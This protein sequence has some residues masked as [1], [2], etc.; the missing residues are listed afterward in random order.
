MQLK[1]N[2]LITIAILLVGCV[3]FFAK[4]GWNDAILKGG[5]QWG[6]NAYLTSIFI[7]GDLPQL[8]RSYEN[9]NHQFGIQGNPK[10]TA[11]RILEAPD[12]PNGNR[13]LKYTYGVAALQV[14]FFLIA[15]LIFNGNG[16]TTPYNFAIYLSC[17]FYVVFGLVL[18]LNL[19]RGF[20]S[21]KIAIASILILFFGSNLFYF[22]LCYPGLSHPYLFFLFACLAHY[23]FRFYQSP[24]YL[25]A[26]I[27]G[28][29]T[30]L[31]IITRPVEA[32]VFIIPL[33]Y[34]I[35]QIK[36]N[37]NPA[38]FIR[39][40]IRKYLLAS[41]VFL[42]IILPQLIY[43]K[44]TSGHWVYDT[45][46][47]E[48]FDFLHPHI[49]DGLF[50]FNNGWLSYT[51]LMVLPILFMIF[52]PK[53][54]NPFTIGII[55][56]LL[57]DIYV[58][59]SWNDWNYHAGL[60]SRPMVECYAFLIIPLSLFIQYSLHKKIKWIVILFII[61]CIYLNILR[62]IQMLSGNFISEDAN[63]QF[64]KQMLF[65]YKTDINDIYAFDLDQAQPDSS[66]LQFVNHIGTQNFET[67]NGNLKDSTIKVEG[68]LSGHFTKQTE[69]ND[70]IEDTINAKIEPGDFIRVSAWARVSS[71]EDHYRMG[72]IVVDIQRNG[73]LIEWKAIR[74]HN[75]LIGT[76]E[77]A[78]LFVGNINQW[79]QIKYF[80]KINTPVIPGDIIKVYA[81][82]PF[83]VEFWVD[84]ITTDLYR[85]K[86][87]F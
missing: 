84:N 73:H 34:G 42:L 54:K 9:K 44:I 74:I 33:I 77:T 4:F 69:F 20:T 35:T 11:N 16:Y 57:I 28:F 8:N 67:Y 26:A 81:W 76:D 29:I 61:S 51:P 48:R 13:V 10:N 71:Y 62:S 17:I 40:H 58:I 22:T 21:E 63:W 5:D 6:Y 66:T 24:S 18:L 41:S 45:Y 31:I 82:N 80:L 79:R 23:T 87:H 36:Q 64:N 27:L 43:W 19:L 49:T 7:Y 39:F 25:L 47:F 14:P 68:A 12:A 50:S 30:G 65:K 86:N 1:K 70:S 52:S 15:H 3:A 83:G 2:T 75:K 38:K 55:L 37:E 56:Y 60:G 32:I 46:P 85:N 53:F 78:S 72:K 59:Y